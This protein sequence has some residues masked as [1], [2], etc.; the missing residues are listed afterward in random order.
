MWEKVGIIRD[1]AGLAMALKELTAWERQLQD[2]CRTRTDWETFNM[3]T[4]GR[5]VATAASR[6]RHS[7]GAH[8]RSDATEEHPVGWQ[9]HIQLSSANAGDVP[10][11]GVN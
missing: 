4:V 3:A 6:R 11:V 9:R 8:F 7:I 5:L 10:A 2:S 1:Q